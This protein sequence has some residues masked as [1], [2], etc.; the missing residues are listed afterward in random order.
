VGAAFAGDVRIDS[1]RVTRR[2][3]STTEGRGGPPISALRAGECDAAQAWLSGAMN[4]LDATMDP[5]DPESRAVL[6]EEVAE[7]RR[8]SALTSQGNTE[9]SVKSSYASMSSRSRS[10]ARAPPTTP[11]DT[12]PMNSRPVCADTTFALTAATRHITMR[13]ERARS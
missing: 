3:L 11:D 4:Q 9:R 2:Q 1:R 10:V 6:G 5:M 12:A 8:L 13:Y 7:L